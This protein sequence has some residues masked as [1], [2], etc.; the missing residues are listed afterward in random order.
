[1]FQ[2]QSSQIPSAD[3]RE[4]DRMYYDSM[5]DELKINLDEEVPAP[6][7]AISFGTHTYTNIRGTF[8]EP[9]AIGTDGNFSFIQAPPKSYKS[10]FVSLLVASYLNSGNRWSRDMKS[11]RNGRDVFHFDTEQGK[12]HCLKVFR[13][14]S[15]MSEEQNGYHTYTLRTIDFFKRLGFIEHKLANAPEGSI[16]LVVIDGIADLVSDVNNI[17]ESGKCVQKLMEMSTKYNCHIVTVIHSNY[18]SEKPTGHLGSFCEKKTECQISLKRQEENPKIV[19]V[20]CKRSR[21][22]SFDDFSFFV[23]KLGYP[24]IIEAIVPTIDY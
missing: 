1:M 6:P 17:E 8:T 10:Y 5:E 4:I 3:E 14:S 13:R 23:N 20:T 15:D 11:N 22:A 21:N 7:I 9:S 16:G 19:D 18:G 12:W 2:Q 24:E